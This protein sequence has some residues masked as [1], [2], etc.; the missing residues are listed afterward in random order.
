MFSYMAHDDSRLPTEMIESAYSDQNDKRNIAGVK[1][2]FIKTLDDDFLCHI[3]K[4]NI[5]QR[6]VHYLQECCSDT[7]ETL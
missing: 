1:R 4:T 7:R 3:L 5:D 6:I 2:K